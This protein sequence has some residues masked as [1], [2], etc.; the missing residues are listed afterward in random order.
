MAGFKAGTKAIITGDLLKDLKDKSNGIESETTSDVKA[1][2]SRLRVFDT[3]LTQSETRTRV[4]V[5]NK[6]MRILFFTPD[7]VQKN[8]KEYAMY[9]YFG[10][11]T[12]R[13]YGPRK[14]LEIS[15]SQYLR[16]IS[17]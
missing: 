6:G 15:A 11:G 5:S 10:L 14:W 1:T 9:P 7:T 12:N 4:T 3:G 17:S 8:G 16:K 2:I 13:R